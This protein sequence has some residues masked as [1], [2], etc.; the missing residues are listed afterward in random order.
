M[1][2][3]LTVNME[4]KVRDASWRPLNTG[5]PVNMGSIKIENNQSESMKIDTRNSLDHRL[6]ILIILID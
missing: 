3:Y 2:V 4:R 1:Q 6:I 5:C